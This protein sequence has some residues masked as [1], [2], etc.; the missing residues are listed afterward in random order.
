M[1]VK[2]KNQGSF[3][4]FCTVLGGVAGGV[5]WLF[6]KIMAVGT[7]FLWEWLPGQVSVPYYPVIVCTLGGIII[8]LFRKRFGDYPEELDVVMGKV[9]KE[10]Y[11]KYDNMLVMIIAAL[12]PLLIGSSIGPE[13]GM[14]GIIVGLCYWVGDNLKF[15]KKYAGEYSEVGVAVTLGV[16]FHAPLFGVFEVV[17]SGEGDENIVLP[18]SS[19]IL[20]YGISLAAGTG[21]YFL[22]GR[23][24]GQG[25][26]SMPSFQLAGELTVGDYAMSIIYILAGCLLAWI[27]QFTH[28]G[29]N[30]IAAKIP[31]GIRE[32][33]GG[34][35][36]G[37]SG[38]LIPV[39]MFSG[40]E[41]MGELPETFGMYIP[42]VW[43]AIGVLKIL[44]TNVCIQSGLKGGHFF[45]L[46]FAGVSFGFGLAG[47]VFPAGGHDVFGAAIV[48]AALLG[49]T[50]GKPLAVTMLMFLCFPPQ[51]CIWILM[52]AIIS[53]KIT[54]KIFNRNTESA[55]EGV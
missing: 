34:L 35:C 28:K 4:L 32:M 1:R 10:K 40:E 50:M 16:L 39:L 54:G 26:G 42:L 13:A 20:I 8:G 45:P 27:Y 14:T 44:M 53:S 46:I 9:K 19:K 5:I 38:M 18:K 49:G 11:Y 6:L 30:K 33:V 21:V 15:A 43:A 25:L 2:T 7:D 52:A 12:L 51:L 23:L 31:Q 17:E 22:L 47:M 55:M 36:L 41:A 29:T 48:T 24:F 37:I 3:L